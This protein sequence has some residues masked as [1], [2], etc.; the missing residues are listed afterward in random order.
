MSNKMAMPGTFSCVS[1][2]APSCCA[3]VIASRASK[4]T[5]EARR[6]SSNINRATRLHEYVVQA[7]VLEEQLSTLHP[8]HLP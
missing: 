2:P 5:K 3:S 1:V 4:Q 8:N 6:L 7:T